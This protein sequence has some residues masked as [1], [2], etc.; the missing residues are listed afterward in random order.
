MSEIRLNIDGRELRGYE[1][2]T[3]LEIARENGIQI[4]TLCQDDRVKMYGSCGVCVVEAEHTPKLLRSCSTYASDGMVIKTDTRRVRDTRKTALE[5]LL[6]DHTGD[7]RP[8]CVLACPAQTDCQGYVGLIAM[9]EYDEALKLVKNKIPLPGSIGRV[10]PHP[11]E[12]ACRRDLVEEPINIAALKAF[13]A[14]KDMELAAGNGDA[15]ELL[16]PETGEDTGKKVAVIG[17]GP[18]G[19]TA[20]YFLRQQ[21]HRVEIFDKMP[22]M[23]G[24]LYYG[25]PEYRLPKDYLSAEI[26]SIHRMGVTFHNNIQVGK[27]I[28]LDWLREQ[29]NA[30]IVAVGAWTSTSLRCQGEELEGVIGGIDF[31]Q[32]VALDRAPLTGRS[33]AVVGGGNTAMDCARTA[34]RL[35]ADKVYNIYRR[36]RDEMPAEDIEIEEAMEEGVE[37]KF[38]TNPIEVVEE[39]GCGKCSS[40]RLQIM[41]LGEPDASG[42]RAPVA[43]EGA[44]ETVEVD[45]VIVAIG[46]KLDVSGFEAIERTRWGTIAADESTFRTSLEGVFAIGDATNNGADIAI[47]AIGEAK[48]AAEVVD[49]FLAGEETGYRAPYLVTREVT[50]DMLADKPKVPRK[51]P[52]H[53]SPAER[54][55]NFLEVNY[56]LTDEQA[57]AE[58]ARCLECGC[59]DYFECQLIDYANQYDVQPQKYAGE[60]HHRENTGE[61]PFIQRNP[62]KCILCG[63]CVRI[64][65]EVV[66]P[67][68][69]G[70]VGRGFDTLVAPS[71]ELPLNQSGCI[72]C[73]QCVHVCPTGAL[74]ETMLAPKQVPTAELFTP[75]TCSFCSV[76][77]S[78]KLTHTGGQLL[79]AL[80]TNDNPA[81][82]LL[83]MKGRFGFGEI[84]KEPR[85]TSPLLRTPEGALEEVSWRD[86]LTW[87][88][89]KLQSIQTIHGRDSVGVAVSERYTNEEIDAIAAYTEQVLGTGNLFSFGK[90]ESG[91]ADVLGRDASTADFDELENTGLILLVESDIQ[92][93]HLIAG[94]RVRKAVQRGAKLI[95]L[96]SFESAADDLAAIK[97]DPGEDLSL[98]RQLAKAVLT[99]STAK[100]L[101]GAEELLASLA[102][103]EVS[104]GAQAVADEYLKAKKAV[105]VFEQNRVTSDAA[106]LLGD[107]ALAGGHA[108]GGRNGVIQLKPGANSQGLAD[109]GVKALGEIDLAALKG[110]VVFGEDIDPGKLSHLELLA[111]QDLHLTAAAEAANLVLPATSYAEVEGSYTNTVGSIGPVHKAVDSP[112][113]L[114]NV[115]QIRELARVVG[116]E[117]SVA[118]AETTDSMPARLAVVD[119]GPL[120]MQTASTNQLYNRLAAFAK[121]QGL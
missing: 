119:N 103:V 108:F 3:V 79:R 42:R 61:H 64:C 40:M 71:L 93:P 44:E 48:K 69:L 12:Q 16:V 65:D 106:R 51:N 38:L 95:V 9:G 75:T 43:V 113:A 83:C 97:L 66:G 28:S 74:T 18:G 105:I 78:Q 114:D 57:Q 25:I 67:T 1:G 4:P 29:F 76:G 52:C 98:L 80:P 60:V 89:K 14:N 53:R 77:C 68:A 26:E 2:Q 35:G 121:E 81:E 82:A 87:L 5:L 100:G 21:G 8:P 33:I 19:L 17:G 55:D 50:A 72:S 37:F 56:S 11:C 88:A 90:T 92:R 30:V 6:S 101:E 22:T 7:C 39:G 49:S 111:V 47:T 23:G 54:R 110:L 36:T 96:N 115:E 41:E 15:A 32:T 118:S 46:Q 73:G 107:I 63:L 91:L 45:T 117:L 86:G 13:V 70:L 20:A 104:G 102:D 34:I 62:D 10:C 59:H 24:M 112:V 85:L 27:D 120:Q 84:D 58:A 109:R 31:L 99:A 116:A 94:L